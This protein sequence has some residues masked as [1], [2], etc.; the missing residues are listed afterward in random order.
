[1]N[2]DPVNHMLSNSGN[3]PM[4][5]R[6]FADGHHPMDLSSPQPQPHYEHLN[7]RHYRNHNEGMSPLIDLYL[8]VY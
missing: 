8:R 5:H 1:M 4:G 3:S 2:G 6:S 7:H